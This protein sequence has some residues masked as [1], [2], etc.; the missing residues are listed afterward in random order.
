MP[1]TEFKSQKELQ[2]YAERNGLEYAWEYTPAGGH[3]KQSE[4]MRAQRPLWKKL[5]FGR[6]LPAN[7]ATGS[8]Q[9]VREMH[10]G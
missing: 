8:I 7:H 4:V 10:H 5:I 6:A 2:D 3:L 1:Q 9:P